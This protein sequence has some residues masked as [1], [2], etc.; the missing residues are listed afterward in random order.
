ME[1]TNIMDTEIQTAIKGMKKGRA[2]VID[3][4]RVEKV[5]AAG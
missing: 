3:E 4:V 5:M 1:L 2:P